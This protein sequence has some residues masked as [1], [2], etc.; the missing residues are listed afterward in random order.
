[1]AFVAVRTMSIAPIAPLAK[2]ACRPA[3]R[4]N[5]SRPTGTRNGHGKKIMYASEVTV[6]DLNQDGSPELLFTT[7]GAPEVLD[8]GNLLILAANGKLLYDIPLPNRGE[9]GNGNGAPAAP[10]IGDLRG[11]GNLEIFVQTF[12]HGMDVFRVP[13]SGNNCLLWPTARGGNLRLGQPSN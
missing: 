4:W 8:S 7:Y 3:S 9:N 5:A 11:D 13:G 1:M 2:P 6:A 12:E 10:A